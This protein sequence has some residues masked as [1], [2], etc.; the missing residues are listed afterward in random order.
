MDLP[1]HQLY[2]VLTSPHNGIIF[3]GIKRVVDRRV[4]HAAPGRQTVDV[5]QEGQWR[6]L[7]FRGSFLT[8][9]RVEEDHTNHTVVFRQ[10]SPGFMKAFEGRWQLSPFTQETLDEVF[11]TQHKHKWLGLRKALAAVEHGRCDRCTGF[12][13][14]CKYSTPTVMMMGLLERGGF[15]C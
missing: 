5:T 13:C 3:K 7:M 9:L 8:R 4:V 2:D 14:M 15:M 11:D 12:S 10:L 6:F 1:P